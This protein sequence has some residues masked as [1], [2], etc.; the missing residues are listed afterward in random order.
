[1]LGHCKNCPLHRDIRSGNV[2][3]PADTNK[4]PVTVVTTVLPLISLLC[5]W[6][7]LLDLQLAWVDPRCTDFWFTPFV[8][9]IPPPSGRE[10][11]RRC[12]ARA[13]SRQNMSCF[14]M[15]KDDHQ[16]INRDLYSHYKYSHYLI[17]GLEHEF[18]DFPFSWEFHN[19]N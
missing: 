1:M 10:D 3:L 4:R 16:S 13:E 12:T 5:R 14:P 9:H 11:V 15:L 6:L 17:G 8:V 18:Y 2:S 19:P 7:N